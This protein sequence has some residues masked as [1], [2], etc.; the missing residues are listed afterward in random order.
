MTNLCRMVNRHPEH[1]DASV[2][3]RDR[4]TLRVAPA[5][6]FCMRFNWRMRYTLLLMALLVAGR[7]AVEGRSGLS[8]S[9]TVLVLDRDSPV[10]AVV[11]RNDTPRDLR[12]QVRGFALSNLPDASVQLALTDDLVVY[13]STVSLRSGETRRVQVGRRLGGSWSDREFRLILD[14]GPASVETE[15]SV[16]VVSRTA[17]SLP[18]WLRMHDRPL[19]VALP[20][21]EVLGGA[22]RV[23]LPSTG[24][25]NA[26]PDR[27]SVLGLQA[28]GFPG[29]TS[30]FSPWRQLAGRSQLRAASPLAAAPDAAKHVVF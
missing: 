24:A 14:D 8:L 19:P 1:T 11:V 5:L 2:I 10:T 6:P 17:F 28:E 15:S 13:P 3:G 4:K 16:T 18:V 25:R 21:P 9:S 29:L 27:I 26:A 12:F 23:A 22:V 30:R 7:I 20:R